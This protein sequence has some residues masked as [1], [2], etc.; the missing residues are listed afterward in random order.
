MYIMGVGLV[1]YFYS[2]G[3][4]EDLSGRIYLSKF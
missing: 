4:F 2:S 3:S 1:G